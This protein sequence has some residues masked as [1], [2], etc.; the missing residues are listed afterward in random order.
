MAHDSDGAVRWLL[1]GDPSVRWQTLRDLT[2]ASGKVVARER[3]KVAS[4][5]W[6]ARLLSKQY[7]NGRW[8]AGKSATGKP[9]DAGLYSPK[10]TST[11]Y[12]MLLLRDFG[13]SPDNEQAQRACAPLLDFGL[14][15]DG[16]V[17]YGTWAQWTR[18]GET[19]I[20]GMVLSILS[21]FEYDDARVDTIADH[22][23]HEQMPDGGWNCR[24]PA[25]ATHASVHTTISALEGLRHYE[26][27]RPKRARVAR[28]AQ[29]RGREFLLAHRLFRSHRT[30]EVMKREFTRLSFPPRW[31]YDILRGLDYFQAVNAPRDER[32]SE[33]VEIVRARA[34]E[35][36]RWPLEH[37]YHGKTHFPLERV[38]APSRWNTLRAMRVLKWWD[39]RRSPV[40]IPP[41]AVRRTRDGGIHSHTSER[42]EP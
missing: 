17:S 32:L 34:G 8:G 4:D 14:Q 7:R 22:L 6:G 11:T 28:A 10:W 9:S 38:G 24:R 15:P 33:A 12:T 26:L 16:G 1:D 42:Q 37:T 5:G 40:S 41:L 30:G 2:G 25:G 18:R 3:A 21:Y 29:K 20:T 23:L 19:C 36:G 39:G 13:L 27:F 35:D 31:H